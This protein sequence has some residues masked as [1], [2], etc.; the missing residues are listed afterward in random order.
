MRR[1]II[2]G[3]WKLHNTLAESEALAAGLVSELADVDDIDII[4]AP[5]FT[6]LQH[7]AAALQDS[8]I[9]LAAQN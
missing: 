1:P 4:V 3:N 7:V 5:V 9:I 2:A 6:S 8:P